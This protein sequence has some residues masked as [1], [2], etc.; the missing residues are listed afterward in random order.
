MIT[1]DDAKT[2]CRATSEEDGL[3]YQLM[4]S[5]DAYLSGAISNYSERYASSEAFQH[6]ADLAKMQII[7]NWYEHRDKSDDIPQT[8]RLAI[9]Q[10]QLDGDA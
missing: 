8:A 7:A 4:D 1:L 2:Y 3:I 6:I 9:V 5:A 10:M